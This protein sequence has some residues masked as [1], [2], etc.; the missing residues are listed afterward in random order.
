MYCGF[1][2]LAPVS[3]ERKKN[4]K[5]KVHVQKPSDLILG[6]CEQSYPFQGTYF[7]DWLTEKKFSCG[8]GA[9]GGQCMTKLGGR[10][11]Q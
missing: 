2:L 10:Q 1:I 5:S 3:V 8:L 7:S 9:L 11:F 6:P 4:R